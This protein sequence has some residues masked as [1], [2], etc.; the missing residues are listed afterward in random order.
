[1][2]EDGVF[3]LDM[4]GGEECYGPLEEETEHDGFTYFG[5]LIILIQSI[6]LSITF[7]SKRMENLRM[8]R[9]SHM[10]GECG[11][12]LRLEKF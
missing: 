7:T 9:F 12:F 1:M 8:R 11:Q 5:I 3:F 2:T 10:T 4:F 6:M